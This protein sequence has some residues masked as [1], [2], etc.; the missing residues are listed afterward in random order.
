MSHNR[1]SRAMRK[2]VFGSAIG[3]ALV[4][5]A[6][7]LGAQKRSAGPESVPYPE[8]YRSWTHVKTA[9][10]HPGH[11]LYEAFGGIHHVYANEKAAAVLRRGGNRFPDGSILVFDLL[12][13]P[14]QDNATGE[15]ARKVLAVMV[16]DSRRFPA[17]GGWGYAAFKGG[18]KRQQIVKDMVQECHN[19]HAGQAQHDYVFSQWRK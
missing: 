2:A 14:T 12:E 4:L 13:A 8:G 19:C 1:P 15:G 18:D 17:T 3:G 5:L 16:K 6:L 10:L 9:I 7:T 11:P